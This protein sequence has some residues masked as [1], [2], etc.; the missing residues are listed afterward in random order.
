MMG[1][2]ARGAAIL[3]V[4]GAVLATV[5]AVH[6][7]RESARASAAISDSRASQAL[8]RIAVTFNRDYATNDAGAVYNRWDSN[9]RSVISRANY[10]QRHRECPTSPGPATVQ[11]VN[12]GANGYWD[13]HYS[14]SGVQFTDYWHYVNGRWLFNLVLSNP[15]AVKLYKLPFNSYASAVGCTL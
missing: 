2:R 6:S 11:R 5:A 3:L 12:P 4:L 9:S 10:I 7:W 1:R 13:V 8:F 15:D 14:I